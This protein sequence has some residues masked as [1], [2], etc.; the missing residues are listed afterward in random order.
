MKAQIISFKCVIRNKYGQV[1]ST[2]VNR[3][4]LTGIP[5]DQ[6]PLKDLARGLEGLHKGET[7]QINLS[8]EQAYGFYDPTK[9]FLVPRKIIAYDGP[10]KIGQVVQ[11]QQINKPTKSYRVA[12]IYGDMIS[13]DAN[14]PFAGQD[15]VFEIETLDARDATD[16]EIE[17]SIKPLAGEN[18]H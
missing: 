15:L 11:T 13:L 1:L 9:V 14:H 7:R 8:T 2:S 10:L 18:F 4:V 12:G 16:A 6:A 5:N 3:E 17:E